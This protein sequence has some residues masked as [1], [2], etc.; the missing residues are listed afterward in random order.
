MKNTT[1]NMMIQVLLA[2]LPGI[3]TLTW[4]LGPGVL[5]NLFVAIVVALTAEFILLYLRDPST[6]G[7]HSGASI[8]S[9]LTDGSAIVT[10][11]L[12][13]V[14]LPPYL[15]IWLVTAGVLFAII[16]GKHIYGGLGHNVFNPAMVGFAL[17]ILSFPLAMSQWP[18]IDS[19]GPN[20][21]VLIQIKLGLLSVPDGI[22]AATPLDIIKFR[23]SQTIDEVWLP[24]YGFNSLAGVGWG[25]I[26]L[27][28]LL[29]GLY[30]LK[31]RVIQYHAPAS[32]LLTL[33]L[34]SMFFYD[35]G[36]SDSLGSPLLHL[37]SS[38]TM[39]A[40]FFIV[41]DPVSSPSGTTGQII[42]GVGVGIITFIIRTTG[43]YPEGIAFAILLM[44]AA[45]PLIDRLRL[46]PPALSTLSGRGES[47]K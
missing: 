20:I 45:A 33:T 38:C 26:N 32:L 42:F 40:A 15:S 17:L 27:A 31:N 16:F 39:I 7:H 10:A 44:N 21:A 37:F 46:A 11:S 12:I 2:L 41:T 1:R 3:M 34:L 4:F 9:Q 30:L 8:K 22:T 23:G 28:F 35:S 25:W 19:T 47:E 29:G 13:A 18:A 14:C 24:K 43:A 36:S 6:S 5:I